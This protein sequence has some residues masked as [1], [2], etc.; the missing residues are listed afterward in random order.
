MVHSD[1]SANADE[2]KSLYTKTTTQVEHA[3]E[4]QVA[5]TEATHKKL[6]QDI[7]NEDT[8]RSDIYL[9]SGDKP[10]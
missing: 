6:E 7:K 3:Q 1:Q 10:R 5:T 4:T 2:I 9:E 8:A